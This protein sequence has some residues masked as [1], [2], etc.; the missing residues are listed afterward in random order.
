MGGHGD[1]PRRLPGGPVSQA[2]CWS[3]ADPGGVPVVH[4]A[5]VGRRRG[6]RNR[7]LGLA[8]GPWTRATAGRVRPGDRDDPDLP[9]PDAGRRAQRDPHPTP[10]GAG[11]IGTPPLGG[12]QPGRRGG[13]GHGGRRTV[14][15]ASRARGGPVGLDVLLGAVVQPV[16]VTLLA[17]T[18][19]GRWASGPGNDRGP[20]RPGR[21]VLLVVADRRKHPL[22]PVPPPPSSNGS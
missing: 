13:R 2:V 19:R 6:G 5:G 12:L 22:D 14:R 17:D 16:L 11:T 18:V 3:R 7:L 8:R 10:T 1:V 4:G 15:R 21:H 20:N 9:G